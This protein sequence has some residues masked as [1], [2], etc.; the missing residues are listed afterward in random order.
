MAFVRAKGTA[1]YGIGPA[2]DAEDSALGFGAHS[3]QERI[4]ESSLYDFVRF[5][6]EAVTALAR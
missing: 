4:R 5:N 3:D 1:C 2:T 6:W